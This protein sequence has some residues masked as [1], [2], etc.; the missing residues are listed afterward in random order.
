LRPDCRT[1]SLPELVQIQSDTGK[2]E[3]GFLR[4]KNS[5][6]D[7]SQFLESARQFKG[8][9]KRWYPLCIQQPLKMPKQRSLPDAACANNQRIRWR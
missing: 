3:A 2:I 8:N 6:N 9:A 1:V 5:A 4:F 7:R